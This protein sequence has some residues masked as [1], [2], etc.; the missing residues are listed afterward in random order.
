[1]GFNQTR[2]AP[3]C[4]F[5]IFRSQIPVFLC[6]MILQIRQHLVTPAIFRFPLRLFQQ[7]FPRRLYILW[8]QIPHIPQ[9]ILD[10]FHPCVIGQGK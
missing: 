5:G 4:F 8:I 10:P 7:K 9:H 2:I 6:Q 1:M 3:Q